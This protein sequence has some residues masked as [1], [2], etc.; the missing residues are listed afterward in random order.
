MSR[1]ALIARERASAQLLS[2]LRSCR[3]CRG[4]ARAYTLRQ[5]RTVPYITNTG[6]ASLDSLLKTWTVVAP[7]PLHS[8][9]SQVRVCYPPRGHSHCHCCCQLWC[10]CVGGRCITCYTMYIFTY[11]LY[12]YPIPDDR[13]ENENE[14]ARARARIYK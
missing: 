3:T 10:W 2:A 11:T 13:D 8:V 1:A 14:N 4:T 9:A 6:Q 7:W 12:R 5:A